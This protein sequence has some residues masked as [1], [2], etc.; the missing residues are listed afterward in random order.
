MLVALV[1]RAKLAAREISFRDACRSTT[2]RLTHGAYVIFGNKRA[3]KSARASR[4]PSRASPSSLGL[5][6]SLSRSF[7]IASSSCVHQKPATT[8]SSLSSSSMRLIGKKSEER[9]DAARSALDVHWRNR[10]D[11]RR[12]LYYV[13]GLILM[14]SDVKRLRVIVNLPAADRDESMQVTSASESEGWKCVSARA[15]VCVRTDR[16]NS[17]GHSKPH[18][19]RDRRFFLVRATSTDDSR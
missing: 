9:A 13:D 11:C 14:S 10:P 6:L 1:T 17:D 4:A 3:R 19:K 5:S 7:T 8:R 16:E 18:R 12:S 2:R 15:C